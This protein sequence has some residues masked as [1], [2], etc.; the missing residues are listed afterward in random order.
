[1][2]APPPPRTTTL[3]PTASGGTV[4]VCVPGVFSIWVVWP[5]AGV[6]IPRRARQLIQ[7]NK[8]ACFGASKANMGPKTA[9][10]VKLFMKIT[11]EK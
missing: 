5:M 3:A 9:N 1:M 2:A 8:G 11:I 7:K 6:A 4:T 10:V